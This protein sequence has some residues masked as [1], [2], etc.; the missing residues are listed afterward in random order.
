MTTDTSTADDTPRLT[1]CL[2]SE[3]STVPIGGNI[4]SRSFKHFTRIASGNSCFQQLARRQLPGKFHD[5]R[6]AAIRYEHDGD[7]EEVKRLPIREKY[8]PK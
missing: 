8:I 1:G 7:T 6:S 3:V 2:P 4:I 5:L